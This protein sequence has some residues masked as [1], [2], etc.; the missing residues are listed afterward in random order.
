MKLPL[1]GDFRVSPQQV[2]SRPDWDFV[3]RTFVDAGYSYRN[4][5]PEDFDEYNAFLLSAGVGLEATLGR[6][7][8]VRVDWAHGIEERTSGDDENADIDID[9]AGEF[10]FLFSIMY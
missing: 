4:D 1:I 8:R 10:H 6:H 3:L 9:K 2:Y 7:L 5:R